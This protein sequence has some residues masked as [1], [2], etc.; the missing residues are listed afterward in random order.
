MCTHNKYCLDGSSLYNNNITII[1]GEIKGIPGCSTG[2]GSKPHDIYVTVLLDHEEL[3]RTTTI[4]KT[5]KLVPQGKQSIHPTHTH[6][7]YS[8]LNEQQLSCYIWVYSILVLYEYT[9]YILVMLLS[10]WGSSV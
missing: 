3:Y 2:I 5:I 7:V 6:T 9:V 4:E 10:S 1:A 8:E